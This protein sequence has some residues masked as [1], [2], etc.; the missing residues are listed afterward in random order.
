VT[1]AQRSVARR[2]GLALA[3]VV[4]AGCQGSAEPPPLEESAASETPSPSESPVT[5]APTL[6]AEAEG[7]SPEAAEAFVRH[8]V[9]LVNY[10]MATGDTAPLAEQSHETCNTCTAI[11]NRVNEVY[12]AGGQLD[13]DGWT[14][15]TVTH[16]PSGNIEALLVAVGID[17]APQSAYETD[18]APPSKS[19]PGRGNLDFHLTHSP[20]GW[21][22]ARLDATQ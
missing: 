1:R 11:Q 14:V 8:Y 5:S 21:K 19:P 7:T 17:I 4:L 2:V 12:T 3:A 13:G 6:P 22:V 9:E 20:S 18:D 10:A 15:R 16:V